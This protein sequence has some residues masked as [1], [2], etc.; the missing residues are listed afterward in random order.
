MLINEWG[1]SGPTKLVSVVADVDVDVK[2]MMILG[3]VVV[4]VVVVVRVVVRVVLGL[5][6]VMM[7]AA[8]PG[9]DVTS[10]SDVTNTGDCFVKQPSRLQL[11]FRKPALAGTEEALFQCRTNKLSCR[12]LECG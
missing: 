11:G 5:A 9:G 7:V 2:S 4:V 10:L 12:F 8:I 1:D 3:V 6:G